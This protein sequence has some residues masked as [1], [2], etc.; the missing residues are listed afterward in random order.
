MVSKKLKAKVRKPGKLAAAKQKAASLA[1]SREYVHSLTALV[2]KEAQELGTFRLLLQLVRENGI[3]ST[4]QL[5]SFLEKELRKTEAELQRHRFT[6]LE[7][8]TR[9]A[10]RL[11][12]LRL[13]AELAERHI[14]GFS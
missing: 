5:R 3:T 7:H 6:Q 4:A 11:D 9:L 12:A 2:P 14:P 8:R 10:E 1:V 13:M